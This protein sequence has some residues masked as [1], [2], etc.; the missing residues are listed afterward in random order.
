MDHRYINYSQFIL[1]YKVNY[2]QCLISHFKEQKSQ[3]SE[4]LTVEGILLHHRMSFQFTFQF[5]LLRYFFFAGQLEQNQT[6]I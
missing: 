6:T 3:E 2:A 1:Y 5:Y 4:L